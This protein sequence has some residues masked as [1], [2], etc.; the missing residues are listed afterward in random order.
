[1]S[2]VGDRPPQSQSGQTSYGAIAH[3]LTVLQ[4]EIEATPTFGHPLQTIFLGGGTPSLLTPEQV[5][6]VIQSL[7]QRFGIAADA[8]ISIE[9]D[10]DTVELAKLQGYYH[11]GINRVSLGA[12]AFQ[13]ELLQACGRTHIPEDID[14]AVEL[15]HQAGFTNYSLDLISGL[16]HQTEERWIESLNRAIAL[17]PTHL[18]IYDL[19]IEPMT[20]FYRWYE[21]GRSPL[22]TDAMAAHLYRCAQ[23][24][25]TQH[26]YEHYEIS[27]Y[28]Q[29]G[30]QCRH[31]RVYWECSPYYGFGMGAASFVKGQ[32]L[33][34]PRKRD[35]YTQWVQAL[36]LHGRSS[37]AEALGWQDHLL[38]TLM[39]G[40]RLSDGLRLQDLQRQFGR[41][42]VIKVLQILTPYAEQAWVHLVDQDTGAIAP[43]LATE[44]DISTHRLRLTD[45]EGF[46]FSNTILASL[47]QHLSD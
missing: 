25:L 11:A 20:A 4:Q 7:E 43:F 21:P 23:Q 36:T 2:I 38:E 31:N 41:A 33:T 34:R 26:G 19:I 1:V 15:L 3:Y 13:L 17:Q 37:G 42:T 35:A 29:P 46:L 39:L 28:A 8:E 22:P 30:F 27:N 10:P 14:R 18:S 16:P 5:A 40:L 9:I 6:T 47:F 44:S 32:R 12:Q 45:P 24:I